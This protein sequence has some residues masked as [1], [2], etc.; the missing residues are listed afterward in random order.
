M[1]EG[2]RARNLGEGRFVAWPIR[3]EGFGDP[4]GLVLGNRLSFSL[5][6]LL[7]GG[8]QAHGE[9]ASELSLGGES[10]SKSLTVAS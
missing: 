2:V 3:R 5:D 4:T 6:E 8:S 7:F 9:E 10:C 1:C